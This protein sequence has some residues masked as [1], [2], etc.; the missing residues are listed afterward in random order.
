M[1]S[2]QISKA[3]YDSIRDDIY[4]CVYMPTSNIINYTMCF[5]VS[6]W[7]GIADSLILPMRRPI[8]NSIHRFIKNKLY[9]YK[10]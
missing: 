5:S 2:N 9:T 1:S 10:F 7:H 8:N 4:N 6:I 3:V